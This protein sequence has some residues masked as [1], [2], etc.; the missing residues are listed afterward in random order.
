LSTTKNERAISQRFQPAHG[1][2]AGKGL[3]E[4]GET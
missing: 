1:D 3:S 2:I 4:R